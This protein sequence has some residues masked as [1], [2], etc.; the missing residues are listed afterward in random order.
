MTGF[1]TK[2]QASSDLFSSLSA[3]FCS[4]H[5]FNAQL[6]KR[7]SIS[8]SNFSSTNP[9]SPSPLSFL[10]LLLHLLH[11]SKVCAHWADLSLESHVF[12][13]IRTRPYSLFFWCILPKGTPQSFSRFLGNGPRENRRGRIPVE[14][15]GNLS[16]RQSIRPDWPEPVSEEPWSLGASGL[17]D[18]GRRGD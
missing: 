16:I 2:H 17:W 7:Q 9:H 6:P 18:L 14:Y 11:R 5:H 3:Q 1:K 8:N 12:P 4:V 15:R 13:S 10:F